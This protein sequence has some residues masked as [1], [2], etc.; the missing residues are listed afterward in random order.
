MMWPYYGGWNWFWMVGMM[1][2]MLLF[3]GGI[4]G[5]VVWAVRAFLQQRPT[6]DVALET[7]RRRLA[8]GE[9]TA[10]EFEKTKRVL[11]G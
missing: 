2:L 5:V 11:Q 6:G 7:L 3:W 8:A 9:I 4:V 1:L 10:D